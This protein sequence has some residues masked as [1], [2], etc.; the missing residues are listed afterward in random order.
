MKQEMGMSWYTV[1]LACQFMPCQLKKKA[2]E[3]TPSV[4]VRHID[5]YSS[6]IKEQTSPITR[7]MTACLIWYS[8]I[9]G[10]QEFG[11]T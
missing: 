3:D 11:L 8:R 9:A 6:L 10:Q 4:L 2:R 5:R 7:I 1:M